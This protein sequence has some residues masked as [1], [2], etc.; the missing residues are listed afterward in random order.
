[1]KRHRWR[2]I[3]VLLISLLLVGAVRALIPDEPPVEYA[4]QADGSEQVRIHGVDVQLV[5]L[6]VAS[7]VISGEEFSEARFDASAGAV[8]VLGRFTMT[9]HG[10][11][12][13]PRAELRTPDG[14]SYEALGLYGFQPVLEVAVGTTVTTTLFFEVPA[15]K[16]SGVI[17][18]HGA[19]PDGL[20]GV[21]PVVTFDL[22][23]GLGTT[24]G[25]VQVP[26]ND[27]KPAP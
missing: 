11:P 13:E 24:A 22:A 18:V 5:D 26:P 6:Q 20:Q 2:G 1:M 21:F 17:G 10:G 23:D 14:Y 7:S 16:V 12:F 25:P 4:V 19:R 15:D 8:L 27:V 9:A 3:L